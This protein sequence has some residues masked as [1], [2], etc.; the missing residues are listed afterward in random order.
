MRKQLHYILVMLIMAFAPAMGHA[1][2]LRRG[3]DTAW[4]HTKGFVNRNYYS[5]KADVNRDANA[6]KRFVNRNY[7][8]TR[9]MTN[10]DVNASKRFINRNYSSTRDDV[11]R[12]LHP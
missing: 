7:Y 3:A 11:N 1:Q 10:K 5:A 6:T 9:D 4:Q 8:S 2:S 12:T